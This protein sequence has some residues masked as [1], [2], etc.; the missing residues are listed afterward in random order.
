[1]H[2]SARRFLL[3]PGPNGAVLAVDEANRPV[4]VVGPYSQGRYA[5]LGLIPGLGSDDREQLPTGS[6]RQLVESLTRWLT[7]NLR[8][9]ARIQNE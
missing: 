6:E 9:P 5:A 7:E 3:E 2:P 4:R 8:L 1:M